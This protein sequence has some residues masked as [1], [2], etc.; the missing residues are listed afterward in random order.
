[1]HA[2]AWPIVD[3]QNNVAPIRAVGRTHARRAAWEAENE[4]G[5]PIG[6]HSPASPRA[7][8]AP[9]GNKRKRRRS[10]PSTEQLD[11]RAG[12]RVCPPG[13][14]TA[15]FSGQPLKKHDSARPHKSA[16]QNRFTVANTVERFTG[17]GGPEPCTP[18]PQRPSSAGSSI[19]G[20]SG[21]SNDLAMLRC[22]HC[23]GRKSP[24]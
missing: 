13:P 23:P 12:D 1:M 18:R 19:S 16:I 11:G 14:E 6:I 5:G 22:A 2:R 20:A 10:Y 4:N 7:A 3:G 21:H 8:H 9:S 15:V 17:T 24:F